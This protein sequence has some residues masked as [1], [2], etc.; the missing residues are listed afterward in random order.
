MDSIQ[1]LKFIKNIHYR[2]T[3][4]RILR[5][6]SQLLNIFNNILMEIY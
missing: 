1:L 3:T 6:S 2:I 4:D 5:N